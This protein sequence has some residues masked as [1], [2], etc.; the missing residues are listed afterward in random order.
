[1]TKLLTLGKNSVFGG[2]SEVMETIQNEIPC[3]ESPL[4]DELLNELLPL[5]PSEELVIVPENAPELSR[6]ELPGPPPLPPD[7]PPPEGSLD[8][9]APE[10]SNDDPDIFEDE[11]GQT[12][13]VNEIGPPPNPLNVGSPGSS[14]RS[15]WGGSGHKLRESTGPSSKRSFGA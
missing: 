14:Q 4:I 2:T 5:N 15:S 11:A 10:E 8:P 7:P 9:E 12:R 3:E 1:M 13:E 6:T